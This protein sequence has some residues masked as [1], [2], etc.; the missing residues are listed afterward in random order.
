MFE[1]KKVY[2]DFDDDTYLY[3]NNTYEC[4]YNKEMNIEFEPYFLRKNN[5]LI[6]FYRNKQFFAIYENDELVRIIKVMTCWSEDYKI[7]NLKDG[8][9]YSFT[10][11]AKGRIISKDEPCNMNYKNFIKINNL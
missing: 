4:I 9:V 3:G 8:I 2:I 5:E 10:E 11:T 6:K 7:L 1:I